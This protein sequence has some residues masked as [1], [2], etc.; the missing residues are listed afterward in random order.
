M[1]IHVRGDLFE[2]PAQVLVNTV[3]TV[4]VMGKGIAKRFKAIY[5]KMF[6]EYQDLCERGVLTIG[7][8]HLYKTAHKWILNFPTKKHWRQASRLE[9]IEAGLKT[10]TDTYAEAGIHSVAFPALGCGNGQLNYREQVEPLM[11]RYLKRLPIA[12]FIHSAL[13]QE[14]A[15]EHLDQQAIDAWLRSEPRSLAY[16]EVSR[17]LRRA[18]A[19]H[20]TLK[21][22][23]GGIFRAAFSDSSLRVTANGRTYSFSEDDLLEFWQ[24]LRQH[25]FVYR[26]IA[27]AHMRVSYLM[28]IFALLKY[29]RVVHVSKSDE[30]LSR[31][32]AK[33]LQFRAPQLQHESSDLFS[34]Q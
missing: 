20:P 32:A 18:L 7:G 2:S 3:N 31:N 28:P 12:V 21:T 1:L 24:Q 11:H 4:G 13:P 27:P 26:N 29:V 14:S 17:D 16:E 34:T 33:A 8:L 6:R 25:G 19:K 23:N 30:G 15:P 9:Y 22:T 10:F 5:P